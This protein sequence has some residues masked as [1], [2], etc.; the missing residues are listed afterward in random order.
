MTPVA[1]ARFGAEGLALPAGQ[2]LAQCTTCATETTVT[3]HASFLALGV[4]PQQAYA[5]IQQAAHA[6]SRTVYTSDGG[7]YDAVNP[8]TGAVGHRRLVLDQSMIMAA[9]DNALND[10]ALQRYY[11][12]D[13]VSWAAKTYLQA[14]TCPS[15]SRRCPHSAAASL[16]ICP[17]C[18]RVRGRAA[19]ASRRTAASGVDVQADCQ[20]L[21]RGGLQHLAAGDRA[22]AGTA[23][24]ATA[25][26]RASRGSDSAAS[27]AAMSPP[28]I[29]A[30]SL[31]C[32]GSRI[33]TATS[34]ASAKAALDW[35]ARRRA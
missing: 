8:T 22:P 20:E 13:P 7:F 29:S 24:S 10:N 17:G 32:S 28:Q 25:T 14:E 9:L 1:T 11:A 3:P 18:R 30:S 34:A 23:R 12:A 15:T 16:R 31:A 33:R 26:A 35:L 19:I 6:V 4:A 2:Q 5:N 27:T 21:V